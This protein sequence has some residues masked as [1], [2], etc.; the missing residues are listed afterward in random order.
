MSSPV[1][2]HEEEGWHARTCTGCRQIVCCSSDY[3]RF[4]EF[5]CGSCQARAVVWLVEEA[6]RLDHEVSRRR[7]L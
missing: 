1:I 6:R 4:R 7:E 2:R 3:A 5:I